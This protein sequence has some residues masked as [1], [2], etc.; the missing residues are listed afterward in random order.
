MA[1][2]AACA[3]YAAAQ[4]AL[5]TEYYPL[6]IGTKWTYRMTDLKTPTSKSDPKRYVQIEVERT[7]MYLDKKSDKDNKVV[8][9]K[10]TGY[11]LKSTSG[12]KV[13]RDHVVVMPDGV[14]RVYAADTPITPPLPFF[15][16]GLEKGKNSWPADSTS[17][18]TNLKGT[19][20]I[21]NAGVVVPLSDYKAIL[22]SYRSDKMG[23]DRIEIDYW[24]VKDVGMV[25]QRIRT[26][27]HE[28][29]LELERFDKAK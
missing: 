20:T 14:Y 7:E 1:I 29:M 17:G 6:A 18:N 2:T 3:T 4:P 25:K 13:T 21:S 19:F 16:L 28:V 12:D 24:F 5:A 23:D 27:S 15:K 26:K 22:V 10:Y 11:L 8:E 9:N